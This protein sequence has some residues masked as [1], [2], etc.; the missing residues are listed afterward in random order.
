MA[1]LRDYENLD[2]EV[3]DLN[4]KLDDEHNT[5]LL[6]V[7]RK[8]KMLNFVRMK[9]MERIVNAGDTEVPSLARATSLDEK[10]NPG[11][12]EER[13]KRIELINEKF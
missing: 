12:I 3:D 9:L 6:A 7:Y 2:D 4:T 11:G 1:I 10:R 13:K 8:V 5:E